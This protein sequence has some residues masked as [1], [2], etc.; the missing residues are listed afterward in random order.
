M[1]TKTPIIVQICA[2]CF[3]GIKF[4]SYWVLLYKIPIHRVILIN[5]WPSQKEFPLV[6][7]LSKVKEVSFK[8]TVIT[9]WSCSNSEE[10]RRLQMCTKIYTVNWL[11][12]CGWPRE[13]SHKLSAPMNIKAGNMFAHPTQGILLIKFRINIKY[14][15]C[16]YY[17]LCIISK[18]VILHLSLS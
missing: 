6:Q 8:S 18:R 3:W 10:Q 7:N 15:K 17:K 11:S 14:W 4:Q 13:W 5:S 12:K 9:P 2:F 16:L 1:P